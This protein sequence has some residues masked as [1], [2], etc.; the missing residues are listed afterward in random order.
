ML[1][2]AYYI[3]FN[4][5]VPKLSHT[6]SDWGNFGSYFGGTAGT[7]F[8]V[9]A[10]ISL[11]EQ[12]ALQKK[13]TEKELKAIALNAEISR[14]EKTFS[15]YDVLLNEAIICVQRPNQPKIKH[16]AN[17]IYTAR[18]LE[19]LEK[20]Y[21][22]FAHLIKQSTNELVEHTSYNE[23]LWYA[24]LSW[25]RFEKYADFLFSKISG[26]ENKYALETKEGYEFSLYTQAYQQWK[27]EWDIFADTFGGKAE[28]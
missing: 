22:W 28:E 5:L 3:T 25:K 16:I 10:F 21:M 27:R 2:L 18:L 15:H 13:S 6:Q 9:L 19:V 23:H 12:I 14:M 8:A 11:R 24:K 4:G 7:L 26:F 17:L 20:H 1:I